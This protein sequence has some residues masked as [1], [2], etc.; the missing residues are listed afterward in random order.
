[1]QPSRP[2]PHLRTYRGFLFL[3]ILVLIGSFSFYFPS[4]VCPDKECSHCVFRRTVTGIESTVNVPE[5]MLGPYACGVVGLY[6]LMLMRD[7]TSKVPFRPRSSWLIALHGK[8]ILLS[9]NG[10]AGRTP[11]RPRM[12][13]R[14]APPDG[15]H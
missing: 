12:S 4:D 7:A 6:G 2:R 5:H 9:L 10:P 13:H 14:A 11:P 8:G 15:V 1:M 3:L